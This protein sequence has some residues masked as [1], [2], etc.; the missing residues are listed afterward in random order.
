MTVPYTFGTSTSPIPLSNLD[1][2]FS[3]VSN[4][5]NINYVPPFTGGVSETVQNK[6]A[7]IVSVKD[8]GAI[9]NGIADDTSALTLGNNAPGTLYFPS[10]NYKITGNIAF[11]VPCTFDTHAVLIIPTGVTVLFNGGFTAPVQQAFN[12]TGTGNVTFN[13]QYTSEGY[14]EWWGAVTNS[15]SADCAPMIN[16]AIVALKTTKLQAADYYCAT[17][18]LMQTACRKLIGC[19]IGPYAVIGDCT[20]VLVKSSTLNTILIG[21]NSLPSGGANNFQIDNY[22]AD[23]HFTRTIAPDV[24][25]GSAA[26]LIQYTLYTE[27]VHCR[28]HESMFGFHILA[29]V[30]THIKNSY[31]FRSVPGTGGT[32]FWYGF[33]LDGNISIGSGGNASVYI[34]ECDAG[35]GGLSSTF[36]ASGIYADGGA[37]DLF[38]TDF[39]NSSCFIGVNLNQTASQNGQVDIHLRNIISDGFNYAGIFITNTS[40]TGAIEI[41]GGYGAPANTAN[42][43]SWA[44]WLNNSKAAVAITGHQV[45]ASPSTKTGGL[46]ISNSEAVTAM[47]NMWTECYQ[48]G[49][50]VINSKN[51][52]VADQVRN[53][54]VTTNAA[55]QLSGTNSRIKMDM[56][57]SGGAS[58][59]FGS[60]YQ[61][62]GA[63][64]TLSEFR[65][66][67][68]DAT[69]ISG[70]STN[71]LN[72]NGTAIT[73]AG[74]FGTNNL[75]QG[76]MV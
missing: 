36:N 11:N 70:G 7:Q 48:Q 46:N 42:N 69:A 62:I 58:N 37:A 68:L 63:T 71:K 14:P 30:Q 8:F 2:N 25:V 60:G 41:T 17:T 20:R 65:C 67:G 13:A 39:E 12:C 6:L 35:A 19:G 72:Y 26:M 1:A 22:V 43:T 5:T 33:Y 18:V 34:T 16:A 23:I 3:A 40:A 52:Y 28:G 76:I 61:I 10:G 74:A 44:I 15:G 9:G 73:T 55:V 75:A 59:V 24:T 57:I 31:A 45:V 54:R 4:S 56:T 21:P 49:V 29:T 32:D 53:N 66:S 27:I 50:V 47:N 51:C 64:S 38:V